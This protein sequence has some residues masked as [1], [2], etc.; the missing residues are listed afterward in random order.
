MYSTLLLRTRCFTV[1]VGITKVL[2]SHQAQ[3]KSKRYPLH[4]QDCHGACSALAQGLWPHISH[5][6]SSA[7]LKAFFITRVGNSRPACYMPPG[8][9]TVTLWHV[10]VGYKFALA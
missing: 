2:A 1:T 4:D 9:G 5:S 8:S 3:L 6:Q 10:P 7:T